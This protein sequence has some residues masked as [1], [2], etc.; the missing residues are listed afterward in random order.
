MGS[1]RLPIS[2]CL[3]ETFIVLL[4]C[5]LTAAQQR[6]LTLDGKSVDPFL[7]ASGK[8]VVL[9]FVRTDCP[10][11]NRYAPKI[12]QISAE[13]LG[14]A[15][16][17]LVYPDKLESDAAVRKHLR[18]YGY[19]ISALRDPAHILVKRAR[20]QFTPEAAVF[21]AKGALIYHGR[22]DDLY[23]SFGRARSVPSTHELKDAIEAALTGRPVSKIEVAGIGCYISDLE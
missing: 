13:Y 19:K 6:A 9:V 10:I 18:D 3:L 7:Q 2:K 15:N 21:D 1:D 5:G 11:S 12:Q 17:W 20:A 22:I 4:F 23:V 14:K 16:F 8:L